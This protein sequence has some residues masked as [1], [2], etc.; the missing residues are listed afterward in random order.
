M[1]STNFLQLSM[2][3]NYLHTKLLYSNDEL[4]EVS[5]SIVDEFM[6]QRSIIIDRR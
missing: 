1:F 6:I 5:S 3:L 4:A 2:K